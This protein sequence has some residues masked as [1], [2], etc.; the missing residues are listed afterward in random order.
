MYVIRT[1]LAG[2]GLTFGKILADI[3]HDA[4]AIV[5]YLL[6]AVSIIVVW[7]ANRPKADPPRTSRDNAPRS[8]PT[9]SAPRAP[10]KP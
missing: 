10:E 2:D 7:R 5:V 1:A 6:I 8:D 9:G 4:A 3:P